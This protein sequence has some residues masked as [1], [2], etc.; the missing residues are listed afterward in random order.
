M[1]RLLLYKIWCSNYNR[2]TAHYNRGT[3]RCV[4]QQIPFPATSILL[5]FF[6]FSRS[7]VGSATDSGSVLGAFESYRENFKVAAAKA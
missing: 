6:I 5:C 7:I 1:L 4:T 3:E 2:L